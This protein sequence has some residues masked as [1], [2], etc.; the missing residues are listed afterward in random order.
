MRRILVLGHRWAGLV[1]AGFLVLAGLTGALLAWYHELDEALSPA[2]FRTAPAPSDRLPLD[3]LTLRERVAAQRP[4][5]LV[6][7][8]SLRR[9]AGENA[10]FY[11]EARPGAPPLANDEVFVDPY[12]GRIVGERRWGDIGQ[13][14]GNLMPFVYRLHYELALGR[15]GAIVLGVVAL[16]WTVD[17]FVGAWLTMPARRRRA[18]GGGPGWWSRWAPAWRLRLRS[19][20]SRLN[21]DLHRAGGL[22]PWAML[23]VL[24]WSSVAFNLGDEVYHPVM[25][26][27]F[28]MQ[29]DPRDL[30]PELPAPLA[31]PPMGWAA[32]LAAARRHMDELAAREGFAVIEESNLGYDAAKGTLHLRVRSSLDVAE[33]LGQTGVVIDAR[34]GRLVGSFVPTGKA[35]GDTITTWLLAL[36]MAAMWGLPMKVFVSVVGV[37]VALLSA[38]GVVIWWQRRRARQPDPA[39]AVA[40]PGSAAGPSS[41]EFGR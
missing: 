39:R 23:F 35:A 12:S 7:Y 1:M 15:V 40:R 29:G 26:T 14:W 17:C 24:A 28:A 9:A 5:A 34:D 21:F 4:E 16:A 2:W 13:G 18:A 36:H 33:R 20:A 25:R 10:V 6:H 37:S 3:P 27:L 19:G 32:G 31:E 38:T 30:A 41:E 22:W 8:V 11:L